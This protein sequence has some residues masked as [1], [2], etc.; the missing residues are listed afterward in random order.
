MRGLEA[1]TWHRDDRS[2]PPSLPPS[3]PLTPRNPTD[4]ATS[5][6]NLAQLSLG[7]TDEP[8]R[9]SG[10]QHSQKWFPTRDGHLNTSK[11]FA[12]LTITIIIPHKSKGRKMCQCFQIFPKNYET[13]I[14]IKYFWVCLSGVWLEF[15]EHNLI[16]HTRAKLNNKLLLPTLGAFSGLAV[17][18]LTVWYN[19][20]LFTSTVQY[21]QVRESPSAINPIIKWKNLLAVSSWV[22]VGGFPYDDT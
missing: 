1:D 15:W 11:K 10:Y 3:L 6:A 8:S 21:P 17:T 9:H 13:S 12:I 18:G 22:G 16:P 14:N 2:L 4:W 7:W 20:A 5:H 19:H